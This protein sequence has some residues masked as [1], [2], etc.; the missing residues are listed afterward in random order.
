MKLAASL[1]LLLAASALAT[2]YFKETFDNDNHW[3]ASTAKGSEA[4]K[5]VL[6]TGKHGTQKGYQAPTDS[7]FYQSS[8]TFPKFSNKGKT[9]VLQYVVK[10]EQNIDCGGGYLKFGPSGLKQEEFHGESPYNIMF[11]PDFC[12]SSTQ[13]VH[14]IFNYKGTNHL[15]KK[16]IAPK[17]DQ[18]SHLYTLIVR[19]DNTYEVLID[20]E[21]AAKG[22]IE[23]DFDVLPPRQ[24]KDPNAHKPADW[25]DAAKI[26]DPTD[27]KPANWDDTPA[28]IIDPEAKKPED[29]DDE[30]D[31]QWEAPAIPNP[32]YK[33]E[34][35]P[36]M[37]PNPA[38]KGPWEHPMIPNPEFKE[39]PNVYAYDDFG[40]VG[41]DIW[42][43]KAG[44]IFDSI[45]ITDSI[46]E[47]KAFG[48]A[49]W[50][51]SHVAEKA[52]FDAEEEANK[53]KAPEGGHDEL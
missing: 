7:R 36:K 38:Y 2:T 11:G 40:Y 52:S 5:L 20:Q 37:I 53:P 12:G 26:P 30:L 49:T 6:A 42:T 3:H 34:W 51:A 1:V 27:E 9:L 18:L 25:V 22:S 14:V 29:W 35:K 43:V 31:G 13:K 8:A 41:I 28:T 47:A 17:K 15:I 32:E 24:I 33:G 16:T 10:F 46:D 44:T 19:P 50:G 4:G 48:D 39:D 23:E 21:S 45:I